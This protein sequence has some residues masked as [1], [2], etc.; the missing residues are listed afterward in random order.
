MKKLLISSVL[1]AVLILVLCSCSVKEE[2]TNEPVTEL[3]SDLITE[4]VIEPTT[5]S[6]ATTTLSSKTPTQVVDFTENWSGI[7]EGYWTD[8]FYYPED[9]I[10]GG[11]NKLTFN[12]SI[13]LSLDVKDDGT[14]SGTAQFTLEQPTLTY[15]ITETS[16]NGNIITLLEY[17]TEIS[18]TEFEVPVT[19]EF[20]EEGI[21]NFHFRDIPDRHQTYF[22][23]TI[24]NY[25]NNDAWQHSYDTQAIPVW[26][27][28]FS[29]TISSENV[30]SLTYQRSDENTEGSVTS[31]SFEEAT[32]TLSKED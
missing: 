25:G 12:Y 18:P 30:L 16:S 22:Y 32:G 8:T 7:I 21:I 26:D 28:Q 15:E 23:A 5:T 3:T 31:S 14:F 9:I 17:R 19:G 11:I 1:V 20:L 29:Y 2:T 13:S 6:P 4:P 10:G 24:D 27:K